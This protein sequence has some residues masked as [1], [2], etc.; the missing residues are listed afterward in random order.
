MTFFFLEKE[1]DI[2]LERES[3]EKKWKKMEKNK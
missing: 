3:P 2:H 1:I